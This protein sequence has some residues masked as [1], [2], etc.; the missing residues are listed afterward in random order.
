MINKKYPANI[1]ELKK[2][3][4]CGSLQYQQFTGYDSI[5]VFEG[6]PK[7]KIAPT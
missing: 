4:K 6:I 5:S 1:P 7:R 3:V 2:I